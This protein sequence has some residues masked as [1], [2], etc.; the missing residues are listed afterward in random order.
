MSIKLSEVPGLPGITVEVG[1]P[2]VRTNDIAIGNPTVGKSVRNQY[3]F[4][5]TVGINICLSHVTDTD[6]GARGHSTGT[7]TFLLLA[8]QFAVVNTIT[9][10]RLTPER[11]QSKIE[12]IINS[13][14]TLEPRTLA[15]TA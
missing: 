7:L 11:M 6:T 10:C 3:L 14:K 15:T 2:G 9:T 8:L 4:C 12:S 5:M 1:S 13:N